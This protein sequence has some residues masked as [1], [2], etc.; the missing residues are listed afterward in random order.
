MHVAFLQR[1]KNHY[2]IYV[3]DSDQKYIASIVFFYIVQ[4]PNFFYINMKYF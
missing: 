3:L 1:H 2:N 4:N